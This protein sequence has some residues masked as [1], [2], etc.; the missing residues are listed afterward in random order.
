MLSAPSVPVPAGL[1]GPAP[2]ASVL[3]RT[4]TPDT[5]NMFDRF[6][7]VGTCTDAPLGRFENRSAKRVPELATP[8]PE[9]PVAFGL[10][11]QSSENGFPRFGTTSVP[12][13]IGG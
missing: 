10:R 12:P 11:A 4:M 8:A 7:T 1:N 5:P 2:D 6:T 3:V 13:P 9:I